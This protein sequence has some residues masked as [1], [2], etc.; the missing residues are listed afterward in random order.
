MKKKIV[1]GKYVVVDADTIIPSGAVY[2]ENDSIVRVGLYDKIA[3]HGS[4]CEM[5]GSADHLVIPG[6]VNAHGHGKGITDFQRGHIDDTLETWKFRYYP[7][8]DL[9]YDTLWNGIRLLESGVTTTMHNHNLLNVDAYDEEFAT[10]IEA[11]QKSGIRLALA[12]TLVNQNLFVYGDDAAFVRSLSIELQKLCR[13]MTENMSRFGVKQYLE[14][15]E[16]LI[17]QYRSKKIEILHGPLSPQWVSREAL[18]EIKFHAEAHNMRIHIHTL[19]T[20]LQKLYGLKT[21]GK[22]LLQYLHDI[23]FLGNNVTCGHCVW[24]DK[25]DIEL[26]A[27]TR[28]SVT[29]HASCNLRVRN[30][31]SPVFAMLKAGIVV[32][33]GMDDKEFG[34]DKDFIEEMRMV[35]KLHRLPSHRLDS[36]HLKPKDCFRMGTEFGSEVLGF[37]NRVGALHPGMHADIVL[38]DLNRMSEPFVYPDHDI[39]DLLIYRGRAIDVDTVIVAGDVQVQN[40]KYVRIDREE[41][42]HKLRESISEDY[43]KSFHQN[44]LLFPELRLNVRDYF[45]SW[46]P[47]MDAIEKDPFYYLNN[48]F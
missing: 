28:T 23:D 48:G 8:V 44:N 46:Y 20:Q 9:Y 7:L 30:G 14:S 18:R 41:V 45:A 35:S 29:H 2:I 36:D 19:Q 26:L 47:E 24:V 13:R 3:Q 34:D 39:I 1:Y 27:A 38:M 11:Y 21:Y 12:P 22:S 15:I 25:N 40:G 37:S 16:K 33:I 10:T 4:G 5:I 43:C 6:L 17:K 32:G 31:I 42:I